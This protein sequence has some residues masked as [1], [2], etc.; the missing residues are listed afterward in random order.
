MLKRPRRSI[1][2]LLLF[3]LGLSS[4]DARTAPAFERSFLGSAPQEAGP[5]SAA[6]F[7]TQ[8][9][10]SEPVVSPLQEISEKDPPAFSVR[11]RAAVGRRDVLRWGAAGTAL[12][13]MVSA[14]G[15]W[16]LAMA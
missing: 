4:V 6:I 5:N 13:G 9:L 11:K 16:T 2:L 3:C 15:D 12:V 1:A 14:F 8:S 10:A 7:E